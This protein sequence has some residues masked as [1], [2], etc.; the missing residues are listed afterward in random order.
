LG[1]KKFLGGGGGEGETINAPPPPPHPSMS[2]EY[3]TTKKRYDLWV[4]I[5]YFMEYKLLF[6]S[7]FL[8][9]SKFQP[10]LRSVSFTLITLLSLYILKGFS[11]DGLEPGNRSFSA[12]STVLW[13]RRHVHKLNKK[14][15]KVRPNKS[16]N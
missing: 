8:V 15:V 2:W 11:L 14:D 4:L 13:K 6:T 5:D 9:L 3:D 10:S 12:N 7:V 1:V 16:N